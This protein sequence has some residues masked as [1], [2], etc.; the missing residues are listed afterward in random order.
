[1]MSK[2]HCQPRKLLLPWLMLGCVVLGGV[3]TGVS[4]TE[5]Q[6]AIDI[7][8]PEN[9]MACHAAV[10]NEWQQSMHSRA[11]HDNDPIY[12]GMRAVRMNKQGAHIA[13]QCAQCHNPRSPTDT[14]TPA[15]RAGVSCASCHNL[16]QVHRDGKRKGAKAL[17]FRNDDQLATGRDRPAGASPV[18]PTGEGV[19]ELRDGETLCLA[20]H[21]ATQTPNQVAACTTGP[22]YAERHDTNTTCVSCHMPEVDGPVGAFGRQDAHRSH[23]FL[24][25][26]RAWYQNDLKI[27]QQAV[28]LRV[29]LTGDVLQVSLQNLSAHAFP[30]GFPGRLAILRLRGTD[31]EG[32]VVWRNISQNP[33]QDDPQAVFNKVYVDAAGK[34]VPAPFSTALKRD[35]RLRSDETRVLHYPLPAS[36][37][38]VQ[39]DLEYRL[40]PGKLAN[41]IGLPAG[42]IEREG[43]VIAQT[44]ARR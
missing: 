3:S 26:H 40:L 36:V 20:C 41:F 18:H 44:S 37:V 35:N 16:A 33:M 7:D 24:G 10:V 12:G 1:M 14:S 6:A 21:D 15:A 32:K 31:S 30:S 25:P 42:A 23:A 11:H 34:A 5:G 17:V 38:T 8:R 39:A 4:A 19:A 29:K 28:A 9:C 22:E 2:P 13:G 27:L 43:R